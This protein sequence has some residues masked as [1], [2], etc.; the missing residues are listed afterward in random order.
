MVKKDCLVFR[1]GTYWLEKGQKVVKMGSK[2]GIITG[3]YKHMKKRI[4]L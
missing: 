1:I 3:T 4:N 2:I